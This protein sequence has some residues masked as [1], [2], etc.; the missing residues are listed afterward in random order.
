VLSV[1]TESERTGEVVGHYA[2]EVS[3]FGQ[4]GVSTPAIGELGKA[5]VD[6]AHRG[7]GLMERMRRF[8][9]DTAKA[10]GMLALFSEPTM[11][12]PYSQKANESLGARA[13][14]VQLGFFRTED[15]RMRAIRSDAQGQR[16]SLLMYYQP[17][18][19]PALRRLVLPPRHRAMLERTYRGC[20]IPFEIVPEA[21]LAPVPQN[22]QLEVRFLAGFD[23]G[24]IHVRQVGEDAV[25]ALRAARD[26]L[27]RRAGSPVIF[28]QLR[29]DDPGIAA[30]CEAAEHLGF[31]YSGMCPLHA[32]G[33]DVLQLQ[34]VEVDMD[35]GK[36]AVAGP[37]A[38]ELLDYV[39]AERARI[40][41]R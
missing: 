19:A 26:E 6:P 18:Q 13:C 32:D 33:Q 25:A 41:A 3:G 40:D 15:N 35:V 31:F 17:L 8:T 11:M 9:E 23:M 5:V 24:Q 39:A 36:L 21:A 28:M 29:L 20:E 16:G 14:A 22:T 30:A 2:L 27:V 37:F 12:H 1:V 7:R 10:R 38:R 34:Y 4:F